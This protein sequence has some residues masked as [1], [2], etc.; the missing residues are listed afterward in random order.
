MK[1]ACCIAKLSWCAGDELAVLSADGSRR[2]AQV[3]DIGTD[4]A[5]NPLARYRMRGLSRKA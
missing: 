5:L 2:R 4:H 3:I 1:S